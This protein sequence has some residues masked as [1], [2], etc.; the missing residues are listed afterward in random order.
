MRA[1]LIRRLALAIALLAASVAGAAEAAGPR[2]PFSGR[3]GLAWSLRLPATQVADSASV[4][5]LAAAA[6]RRTARERL[7]AADTVGADSALASPD[8]V[9]SPWIWDSV[10]QRAE[11][12]LARGDTARADRMLGAVETTFWPE[13]ERT[14][15]S[16]M[17][18]RTRLAMADTAEASRLAS[19]VLHAAPG[20]APAAAAVR[21]LEA[22]RSAAGEM[23]QR[24][25]MSAAADVDARRG[26]RAAA[27][28]RLRLLYDSALPA[29]RQSLALRIAELSR[30]RRRFAEARA[31][32]DS[33]L[34]L[35]LDEAG[36]ERARLEQAR[37][38]RAD[39][40]SAAAIRQYDALARLATD[41]TVRASA[42]WELAREAQDAGRYALAESAFVRV[43][44]AG[45]TRAAESRV[46]AGLCAYARGAR[47]TAL[48]HWAGAVGE[49]ARFWEAVALRDRAR[50]PGGR[51]SERARADS[52][53]AALA[54]R[55]GYRF[56]RSAARETLGVRGWHGEVAAAQ[57]RDSIVCAVL[58]AAQQ[59]VA[60][61]DTLDGLA[62]L[63][64]WSA[65]DPRAA[66]GRRPSAGDWLTAA[67]LAYGAARPD[68]GTRYVDRALEATADDSARVWPLIAWAYPPAYEELVRGQVVDSLGLDAALLWGLIRQESR[69]DPR[70][71][72]VS[73]ALGLAQLLLSTAGDVA[74]WQRDPPPTEARLFEPAIAVRYG[75]R[76][77]AYLLRRFER[78]T[79]V[80]LA[81]YN[82]GPGT[83]RSDWRTLIERGGEA[84]FAEFASNADSQDY[85]RRILGFAQAYRE[86][87]P[88]AQP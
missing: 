15:W 70:A 29:A 9:P 86:L 36:R 71:R 5:L 76:Y 12:A 25:E 74:R 46:L 7:A 49:P 34:R 14:A 54:A 82:A 19:V 11:W 56:H 65:A 4:P 77:L 2:T 81:A 63:Q 48:A 51:A 83:I 57:C 87:A 13:S 85:A 26:D 64:R 53:L 44:S 62:L 84:L 8:L 68:M 67:G 6:A 55:P 1:P 72:S 47:D 61:G 50:R 69:F 32:A 43:A 35:A 66:G 58:G 22:I 23:L 33:A 3:S 16:V 20:A 17:R 45:G 75:A 88:S 42:A 28:R 39:R 80:A 79:A 18:A 27:V 38:A 24:S 30:A 21:I 78:R 73:D 60:M 59:L 40:G 10:R 41:A 37:I 52:L 31:W